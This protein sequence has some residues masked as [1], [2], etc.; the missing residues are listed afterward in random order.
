MTTYFSETQICCICG[1]E[2]ECS[3]L[4]S[5]N[6]MGSPDLDLRPPP[7]ERETMHVWFQECHSCHYVSVDLA[8]ESENAKSI[9]D[10]E[11][12]QAMISR[13]EI[14]EIARRFALC[15]LLN[16]HDR[17]IAATALLRAAWSCDDA[18]ADELAKSFRNQS[19]DLLVKMQPFEDSEEQ[20]TLATTLV[21][22]LRR[23]ERFEEASKIANLLLKFKAVKRTPVM[24]AVVNYQLSLC[25]SQTAERRQVQ[26]AIEAA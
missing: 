8:Q 26:D 16:A 5:T 2:N 10:S 4:G 6:T 25:D 13:S 12:Y 23:A 11:P 3:M 24:L 19:A 17:E 21:D 22:V 14:P 18:D 9:V 1:S 20:A 7:M 15:A